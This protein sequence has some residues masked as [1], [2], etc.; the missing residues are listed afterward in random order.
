MQIVDHY[1]N[2]KITKLDNN[3]QDHCNPAT[4]EV[5]TRVAMGDAKTVDMAVKSSLEAFKTWS[6]TAPIKR[7]R[8]LFKFNELL[9]NNINK[10]AELI[11]LEHGKTL[12]DARG[13]VG[14]AIEVVEHCCGIANL[15]QGKFSSNISN[16]IDV[17]TIR[18][19]LGVCAG[20]GPFNFPIMVPVWMALP[21]IACGNA[22]I[23]KP[24]EKVPTTVMYLAELLTQAGLPDGVLNVVNGHKTVVDS[25]LNH[26][27]IKAVSA[28]GSTPIAEYIYKTATSNNKRS[29]TFGGAKN[30][31]IIMPDAD[32]DN[33]SD[34]ISGAA[35][36]AAGERCMALSVA[37]VVGNQQRH[38]EL[39]A[40]IK[41]L[42]Q[43]IK[44]GNGLD[45]T[46][47]MGP[48]ITRDHLNKIL[49][50]IEQG[51][52]QG[53][54]LILDGRNLKISDPK[55]KN[56]FYLGPSIFTNV[57]TDMTIYQE[58]IFGP[59]LVVL[60]VDDYQ[61]ALEIIN[62]NMYGNGSSIF[63][64]D[65]NISRN[66]AT[67]VSTGMVGINIPIPVP[68]VTHSFGGW[69]SSVFGDLAM[70][71]GES[72]QFYTKPKSITVG[73]AK[74]NTVK[75]SQCSLTMPVH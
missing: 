61:Q 72:V 36:G 2:G 34:Q 70:H 1:I 42:A 68:F 10:L 39:V 23:I 4:G 54:D 37:V 12:A 33:T 65:L 21:A 35:F 26:S 13:S 18:Q 66:F 46:S 55:F 41:N 48:L 64:N 60:R 29:Q 3:Y 9:N 47:D 8:I 25:L 59:V 24:S 74:V 6:T 56:G 49:G 31:C 16:N 45:S 73:P 62:N 30:H 53:A 58:E 71:A 67:E 27:D 20:V 19:P 51:V 14:R 69:K 17:Y 50:Y 32:L 75:S 38:D 44:V 52:S 63:T 15:L 40:K 22:F 57:R 28:V 11:T 5:L 43:K 7:A